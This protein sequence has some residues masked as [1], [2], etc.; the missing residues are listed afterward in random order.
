MQNYNDLFEEV[1]RNL[2]TFAQ[3]NP[4]QMSGFKAFMES[5]EKPGV[6]DVKQKHLIA[7]ACSISAHCEWCISFHVRGAL[8]AGATRE[9]VM[10]S[11]WV[12]VLMGGGPALMYMQGVLEALKDFGQ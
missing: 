6:L 12:A 5:V 1:Q 3:Q 2:T 11:A 9:E 4:D 10:E 8:D 7:T